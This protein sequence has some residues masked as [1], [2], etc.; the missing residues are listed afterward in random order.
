MPAIEFPSSLSQHE[1]DELFPLKRNL[2]KEGAF[3][4]GLVLSG[5]VSAGA[6][7]AGVVDYLMQALDAWALAKEQGSSEAPPHEVVISTIAGA[8]GGA[9]NAAILA[10][11]AGWSFDRG[12]SDSNPFYSSWT[13]GVNLM[14]LLSAAPEAEIGGI[15]SIFNCNAIDQQ[16]KK[17]F[18]FEGDPLGQAGTGTP[19]SR[20][21]FADPLRFIV[22]LANVTGL[23]YRIAL[24]GETKLSND[25]ISH[26]DFV[27][28]A[29]SVEGG[30]S[31]SPTVRPDEF[32]LNSYS[33][34]NWDRLLAAGLATSAFPVAFR[35]RQIEQPLNFCGYRV[36]PVPADTGA[37]KVVQLIPNWD[38]LV[39]AEPNPTIVHF[40]SVDGGTVNNDPIDVVRTSLAGM[41]G[42][43]IRDG[44][45]AD[46]AV[47]LISPLIDP[48]ALG[49]RQPPGLF[50]LAAPFIMSLIYQARFRPE[51]IALAQDPDIYS[52]FLIAPYGRAGGTTAISG[53]N[54]S[55][56]GGLGGFL[57][58][59]DP[60]FVKYDYRLGRR[61]AYEFLNC[62]LRF[63]ET[64][65][66][67]NHWTDPQKK[68]QTVETKN[69]TRYLRLIPL[70]KELRDNPPKELTQADWPV[71]REFPDALSDAF[72]HRL[73]AV[74]NSVA[75]DSLPAS[76]WKRLFAS[77]Y[78]NLGWTFVRPALRDKA[79][80]F[81]RQG[82]IEQKLLAERH[83]DEQ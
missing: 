83:N 73:D 50:G 33:T 25:Q 14:K 76:W 10:R 9:I 16:A 41:D 54:A 21:Y 32:A 35:S 28:F 3:E 42:R 75:T 36:T 80:G 57:G 81:V 71:L 82:L 70:M 53:K 7:T 66:V 61:N 43:N 47:I 52:R 20:S 26:A 8:S 67:F 56:S 37:P 13:T 40:V 62:Q 69:G 74:Y 6:Y 29:L 18:E 77:T 2:I 22:M 38:K 17:S 1:I 49:P 15:S 63:P 78:L 51:D 68:D 34:P 59:V 46:R 23:P 12:D 30:I 19:H 72:E 39:E 65:G 44:T 48:V 11:A 24:S 4:L 45:L 60:N 79:L 55:A 5:T 27:Q 31:N 64:N 58:Y